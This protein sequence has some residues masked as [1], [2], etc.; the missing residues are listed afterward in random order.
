MVLECLDLF[1]EPMPSPIQESGRNRCYDSYTPG[2]DGYCEQVGTTY[3]W[4][5]NQ[6]EEAPCER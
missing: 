4:L 2:A 3:E 5:V 6:E 1:R